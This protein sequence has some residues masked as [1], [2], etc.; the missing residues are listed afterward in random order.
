MAA[1][2][3][4]KRLFPNV[5]FTT[6]NISEISNA[7]STLQ[8]YQQKIGKNPPTYVFEEAGKITCSV[9]LPQIQ[10]IATAT[11][12]TKKSAK[13]EAAAIMLEILNFSE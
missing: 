3:M 13:N 6:S 11:S 10:H 1:E 12:Q 2:E 4:R 8:E 9:R 7:V 5:E